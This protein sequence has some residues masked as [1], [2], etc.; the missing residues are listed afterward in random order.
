MGKV[1]I[2]NDGY[3]LRVISNLREF[4]SLRDV[5][6]KLAYKQGVLT[7][8]LCFDWFK[9]WLEHFLKD[10]KLLIL[11]LYQGEKVVAIAPFI[12]LREKF[13]RILANKIELIGNTYSPIRS[14]LFDELDETCKA[15][16]TEHIFDYLLNNYKKWD[17]IDL[18]PIADED[19]YK[20]VIKEII[21]NSSYK[22]IE[23]FCFENWYMD[24]I[25]YSGDDYLNQRS[26]P[27]RKE[28]RKRKRQLEEKGQLDFVVIKDSNGIDRF[29]DYY[30]EIYAKS[31]KKQELIGPNFHRDLAK[32]AAEKG[33]L[34]LGFLF[35]DETPIAS[36]FTIVSDGTAYL[37]K[38]AYDEQYKDYGPG[39]LIRTEMIKYVIDM[40]KIK[41]IDLGQGSESY[42]RFFVSHKRDMK[43]IFIFNKSLKGKFLALLSI[44]ILPFV[45]RHRTIRQ[46]KN[47][48]LKK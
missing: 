15:I 9:I 17:I 47:I 45:R 21:K 42:K 6:N 29:A 41:K 23:D 19:D 22:N 18:N 13:K 40:D 37:L 38:S 43:E 27:F 28:L 8:F 12:E 35:L 36:S 7:P 20:T 31:W 48:L 30:Y 4:E 10:N 26:K 44:R 16:C 5:W 24:G 32:M 33:W 34:R 3:N 14:I 2:L 46:I 11:L 39:T 25:N 1:Y